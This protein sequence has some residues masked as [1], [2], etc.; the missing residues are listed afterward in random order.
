MSKFAAALSAVALV[1]GTPL[2]ASAVPTVIAT[3]HVCS[4]D[5]QIEA[6]KYQPVCWA[7]V[8]RYWP[9][10]NRLI[11]ERWEEYRKMTITELNRSLVNHGPVSGVFPMTFEQWRDLDEEFRHMDEFAWRSSM[12]YHHPNEV[13]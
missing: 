4:V 8:E 2:T 12:E 5:H 9:S 7:V 1:A 6:T 13:H 10:I 3:Q 11:D